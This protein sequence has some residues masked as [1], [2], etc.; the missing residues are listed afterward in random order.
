MY[1]GTWRHVVV[2]SL[3]RCRRSPLPGSQSVTQPVSRWD[4][5]QRFVMLEGM[6]VRAWHWHVVPGLSKSILTCPEVNGDQRGRGDRVTLLDNNVQ[7]K[8]G[9]SAPETCAVGYASL[10]QTTTLSL[11]PT[12]HRC[13]VRGHLSPTR[14]ACRSLLNTVSRTRVNSTTAPR[15][16]R[17]SSHCYIIQPLGTM[18]SPPSFTMTGQSL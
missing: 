2:T 8:G 6:N 13:V 7:A 10:I 16:N 9:P 18:P 15:R 4:T 14:T 3:A 11:P 17:H 12:V 5:Q 1:L